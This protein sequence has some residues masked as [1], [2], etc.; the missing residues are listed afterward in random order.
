MNIST[1]MILA[2]GLGKRLRPYTNKVP[3]P[4]IKIGKYTLIE[5]N[6]NKL[7]KIGFKKVV[8]N[9]HYLKEKIKEKLNKKYKINILFSEEKKLLNTGGGVKNALKIIDQKEFFVI[10]SDI[11]WSEGKSCPFENLNNFWNKNKMDA[12]LLLYPTNKVKNKV[13]GDFCLD[14]SGKLLKE[15]DNEPQYIFTGIQI[16]KS[17]LFRNI[18]KN[19]FPLSLIYKKLIF[20]K[21]I[22]GLIYEGKWFHLGTL[23]SLKKYEKMIQ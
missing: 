18:K 21:R 20:K 7:E 6:I 23:E 13:C 1:V 5:K 3:K 15:K 22:Y 4:L 8:I 9:L 19:S 12:L 2:A 17:N 10:N 11:I 16:L 14:K